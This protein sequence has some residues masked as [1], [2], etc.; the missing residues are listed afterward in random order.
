ME[1]SE[2]DKPELPVDLQAYLQTGERPGDTAG[3][4]SEHPAAEDAAGEPTQ[5][6]ESMTEPATEPGPGPEAGVGPR[7]KLRHVL[8]KLRLR[9]REPWNWL[10]QTLGACC[11][12]PA[13]LFHSPSLFVLGMLGVVAGCLPLALPPM[14][15]TGLKALLPR[16]ER[17]IGLECAWLA[18]PM[19]AKKKRQIVLA[20]AGVLVGG[21]L[22]W[23]Q[24]L[25]P[26][27]LALMALYLLRV[28]RQNMEQGIEP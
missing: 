20:A 4:Q 2:R 21:W 25:G 26:I 12:P 27:G 17:L 11:L 1:P 16:L 22:L 14:Q 23:S 9:R 5:A 18:R 24:E 28:R 13:L 8:E 15:H 6:F 19:D 3:E 10:V 7:E